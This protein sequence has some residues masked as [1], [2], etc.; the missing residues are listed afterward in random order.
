MEN[1][2]KHRGVTPLKDTGGG[3]DTLK[4]GKRGQHFPSPDR[5]VSHLLL[6]SLRIGDAVEESIE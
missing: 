1:W 3:S 4:A 2:D 6:N 5:A